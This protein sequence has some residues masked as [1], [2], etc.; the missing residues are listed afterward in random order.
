[1]RQL[2]FQLR[3]ICTYLHN[4]FTTSLKVCM[5]YPKNIYIYNYKQMDMCMKFTRA[6]AKYLL[7][8]RQSTNKGI[9]CSRGG[10]CVEMTVKEKKP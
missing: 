8:V 5:R 3:N 10:I 9:H 6:G 2:V 1:M 4:M 7:S